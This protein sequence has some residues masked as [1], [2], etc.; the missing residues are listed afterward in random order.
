MPYKNS[1]VY[2]AHEK[3]GFPELPQQVQFQM[4]LTDSL[5]PIKALIPELRNEPHP[6]G[7]WVHYI[8]VTR[9]EFK[10]HLR[11]INY[12]QEKLK[13]Y[14][15]TYDGFWLRPHTEGFEFFERER[16]IETRNQVA[17]TEDE[18]LDIFV[19]VI[20]GHWCK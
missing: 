19:E 11:Q 3:L 20:G 9:S 7:L 14:S 16:G 13:A 12:V 17:R 1:L 5:E 2:L 8:T 18:A 15:S 10:E 4:L 6:F